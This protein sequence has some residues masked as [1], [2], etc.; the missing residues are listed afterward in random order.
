MKFVFFNPSNNKWYNNNNLDYL[1]QFPKPRNKN[2]KIGNSEI[3]DYINSIIECEVYYDQWTLANRYNKAYDILNLIQNS[4]NSNHDYQYI[5][6]WLRYSFQRLL[7]WQRKQNTPPRA[8]SGALNRLTYYLSGLYINQYKT[9]TKYNNLND[10][11]IPLIKMILSMLGKGTGNGQAIRDYILVI[12]HKFKLPRKGK[13]FYEQWHQK[14]HNNSTP[15]DIIICEALLS[16]LKTNDI[17]NYWKVLNDNGINRERLESYERNITEEPHHNYDYIGDFE[18]F[19]NILKSVHSNNDLITMFNSAKYI[20]GDKSNI[21]EDIIN[22]VNNDNVNVINQIQKITFGRQILNKIIENVIKESDI[23]K[24]RDIIFFDISLENYIRLLV[25]K[26]IHIQISYN[27]Y[28][29]EITLILENIKISYFNFIEINIIYN[30]WLKIVVSKQNDFS[31]N[32]MLKIKSVYNRLMR[33]LNNISDY[34]NNNIQEKAKYLGEQFNINKESVETFS[35]ELIRGTIFFALSMLLKKLNKFIREKTSN[36]KWL[37][38]SRG[39]NEEIKG[40]IKFEKNLS[41]IQ[42]E[43]LNQK[44]ILLTENINGNEEIPINCIGL[45][46]SNNN[47]NYP[48]VLA[49]VSVRARNLK[50]LFG[51]CLDEKIRNELLSLDKKYIKLNIVNTEIKFELIDEIKENE[52]EYQQNEISEIKLKGNS[53]ESE[54]NKKILVEIDEFNAN[55][56]GE[57]SLNT[58]ILFNKVPNINW[59]KYPESFSIPFNIIS[60]F[61]SL[62]E[63]KEINEKINNEINQLSNKEIKKEKIILTLQKL[64]KLILQIN[65]PSENEYTKKLNEKLIKFGIKENDIS[66]AHNS[67]KKVWSSKY[68]ERV[69]LSMQKLNISFD[70]IKVSVLIQKII[71]TEYAFVIHTKNPLNNN[72]NEIFA[73]V[74]NGM[75]ETLVGAYEGQS[76]SFIYNKNNKQFNINSY[77][78]KSMKLL[79]EGFIFR[80]DSNMEDIENFSG[81]GLFDSV[82]MID[83][84]IIYMKYFDDKLYIDDNFVNKIVNG[85]CDIGINVEM[86]YNGKPQD[87][88]GVYY[89]GEFYI[90]QSR[91]QV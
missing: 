79:N 9:E 42:F 22:N 2:I 46:V 21:Y 89:N 7:D 90:V 65:F 64:K 83:D 18:N 37:I 66:K 57:K 53:E 40:L 19:L 81:A 15:D 87:I 32:N 86:L 58:K 44:T 73:E 85:I 26:I 30:D 31:R 43:K 24:M 76:F 8:L 61:L 71:P 82:P 17:K 38:I 3:P 13:Y 25:E 12:M 39:V 1:I 55:L 29:N 5:M 49:H 41:D 51:A 48:D 77:Q 78:N 6:I 69:Y 67:I 33:I 62:E 20:I 75:G 80:S 45:I 68:N 50:I 47:E 36:D 4:T 23:G 72:N 52:K 88:E 14:L 84:K 74:V 56:V 63:N 70:K 35:E 10:S 34:F 59:L 16:F 54:N 60:L 91:P 11:K 27:D 28:I